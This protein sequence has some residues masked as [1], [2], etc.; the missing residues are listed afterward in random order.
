MK[1]LLNLL[2]VGAGG[3]IGSALRQVLILAGQNGLIPLFRDSL[4]VNYL[5]CLTLGVVVTL[6][7]QTE[8]LSPT[9]RLFLATGL[10]GGFT[11]MSSFTG[12]WIHFLQNSEPLY[13][14]GHISAT[15]AG[16]AVLFFLGSR[17]TRF[18]VNAA[19]KNF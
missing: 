18:L 5:G 1:T 16:S 2:A 3:F 17:G 14:F 11:T 4:W 19:K 7:T 12:E 15:L 10:C 9:T 13:A 8:T 6:A